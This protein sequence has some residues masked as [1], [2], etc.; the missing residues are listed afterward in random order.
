MVG[1]PELAESK[2]HVGIDERSAAPFAFVADDLLSSDQVHGIDLYESRPTIVSFV[3]PTCP[4]CEV[5]GPMI[6]QAAAESPDVTIVVVHSQ[7]TAADHLAYVEK[8]QLNLPNLVHI[9][10]P[11]M[12]LW[13]RFNVVSQPSSVLINADGATSFSTGALGTNGYQRAVELVQQ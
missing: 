11:D 1:P 6:A 12:A 5:E 3:T 7:G 4:I 13:L 8:H 10:D 9:K 2:V